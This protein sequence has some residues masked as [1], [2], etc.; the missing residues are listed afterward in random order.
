MLRTRQFTLWLMVL[1]TLAGM[2]WA[3]SKRPSEQPPRQES[4][5][6]QPRPNTDQRGTDESPFVI[7]V[8]PAPQAQEKPNTDLAKSPENRS[9]TWGLSD[10]IAIIAIAVGFLQFLALFATVWVMVR[11]GR[12]QLRAYV[13]ISKAEISDIMSNQNLTAKIAVR[14]FGQTPAYNVETSIGIQTAQFPL[15]MK[16]PIAVQKTNWGSWTRWGHNGE[17]QWG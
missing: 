9:D 7:K 8:L 1:L 17:F 3:K 10:K 2:C 14:N 6:S 4:Q 12:R 5:S 15:V 11:N 16:L 13:F